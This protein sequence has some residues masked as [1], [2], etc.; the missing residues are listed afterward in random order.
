MDVRPWTPDQGRLCLA[1]FLRAT[2]TG[3]VA[4]LLGLY[5]ARLRLAPVAF[6]LVVAAGLAGAAS[7]SLIATFWGDRLGRRWFL[8]GLSAL[9]GVGALAVALVSEPL[10][11]AACAFLGMLNGMGRDRGAALVLEQAALPETTTDAGRTALFAAYNVLQDAGHAL[12]S[13]LAVTPVLLGA[14]GL[15]DL[16][17]LRVSFGLVA[18]LALAP[19]PLYVGLSPAVEGAT[20][21]APT[22][23]APSSR[24]LL[25]RISALFALDS[26]GGGFLTTAFLS[27]FFSTRFSVGAETLGLLFFAARVLNAL[28]HVGAAFL[29][30]RIGLVNTMVFTHVPCSLLLVTVAFAPSFPIAA[31]LFLLREGL[32]EMDVPTRQSYVMAVVRK[33]ERTFAS[34]LTHLVR[35]GA[36]A[37]APAFAGLLAT[38]SMLTPLVVG[39]TMKLAYDGLL[40][41]ACRKVRPPEEEE[42]TRPPSTRP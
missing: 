4:V 10:A 31:A 37:V 3:L 20:V 30:R 29:A 38:G 24:R 23:L 35:M 27:L 17:A 40:Y 15:G 13:L 8:V 41:A 2:A 34:G 11:L 42:A 18:L 22:R 36:W 33:E 6:G 25:A 26:L 39:A 7:A 1:A 21:A 19:L 9:G 5:L 32:A 16:E 28:S 12:G 14:R